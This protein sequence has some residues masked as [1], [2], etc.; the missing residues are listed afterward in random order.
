MGR[1]DMRIGF[2]P[3][4]APADAIISG[5]EVPA[6]KM[7]TS[8]FKEFWPKSSLLRFNV[9]VAVGLLILAK[10]VNVQVPILFK[11]MIDVL[12]E[13]MMLSQQDKV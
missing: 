3:S 6:R 12:S 8:L 4:P 9:L 11:H 2:G 5:E 7:L 13:S 10:V 1:G